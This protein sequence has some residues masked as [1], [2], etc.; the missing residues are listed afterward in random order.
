MGLWHP[1]PPRTGTPHSTWRDCLDILSKFARLACCN[2]R[3]YFSRPRFWEFT[4][5]VS[6]LAAGLR[7]TTANSSYT[8][9]ELAHQY[10]DSGAGLIITADDGIAT[11]R[12]MFQELGISRTKADERTVLIGRD[13]R[14]ADGPMAALR[15]ECHGLVTLPDSLVLGKLQKEEQFKGALAHETVFICYS[16]GTTGKPKVGI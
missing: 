1:A 11:V 16:S 15:P 12:A 9:R 7:C 10:G 14:W 2:L 13:L 4:D 8:S 5:C 3:L 6:G